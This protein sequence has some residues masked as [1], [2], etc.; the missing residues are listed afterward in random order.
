MSVDKISNFQ[1]IYEYKNLY[2]AYKKARENKR[3]KLEVIEY[4]KDL[5]YNLWTLSNNIKNENFEEI[6]KY[7]KFNVFEPKQR[8]IFALDFNGRI[9]QHSLCDNVIG[10]W[11]D[12]RLVYDCA[13][14]RKNKGTHFA[15]KRLKLFLRKYY[16]QNKNDGYFLKIDI[17]KYFDN[18]DHEVL[19]ELIKT[20]PDDEIKQI[21][22]IIID[23]YNN[24]TGKGL[25][26]G[27]QTSQWFALF[28][29][30]PVDRKIKEQYQ[31]KYYVRY[32]DDLVLIHKDKNY[33]R[34][35]L[36]ELEKFANEYLKLEF[37]SKTQINKLSQGIDFL[38][39]NFKLSNTGKVIIKIRQSNKR[40]YAKKIKVVPVNLKRNII[41]SQKAKAIVQSYLAHLKY[42]NTYNY[43][44]F[45]RDIQYKLR[46][47]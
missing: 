18:V 34:K 14:C 24:N 1:K 30:N 40:R 27:N 25:P 2:N 12:A 9:F 28:Y 23:S 20:Y 19:K 43:C 10:D 13:A 41:T 8:E 36:A 32:M 29:L 15:I 39:W 47:T 35:I 11:F 38:G 16:K 4:E 33:L 37:N 21:L 6:L 26:I 31:I 42:G 3:N 46:S 7:H 5:S 45:I 22:H 44:S 17:K